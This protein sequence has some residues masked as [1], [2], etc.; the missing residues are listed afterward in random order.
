MAFAT[1]GNSPWLRRVRIL[2]PLV[3]ILYHAGE[4]WG[5]APPPGAPAA[6]PGAAAAAPAAPA[7]GPGGTFTRFTFL[8]LDQWSFVTHPYEQITGD[9]DFK[10]SR[11][12]AGGSFSLGGAPTDAN[13][14]SLTKLIHNLPPFGFEWGRSTDVF[15]PK[16]FTVGFDFYHFY[17]FDTNAARHGSVPPIATDT[18]LYN[19][20]VR[21]F[22]FDPTK[23][24]INY[25]LG[26]GL[27]ILEGTMRAKPY[28]GQSAEF[29]SYSQ[30]P[31]GTTRMGLDAKG[32]NF[33]FRYELL[34]V[35]ADRV[36]LA[37]NPYPGST[38]KT[39]DFS[40]AII[41]LGLF[42]EFK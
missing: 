18:F 26:V 15:L 6:A 32:E 8:T 25:F 7:G 5:Q 10:T 4:S 35:N 31:F 30:N 37:K 42:Y 41:R 3:L 2:L 13:A 28:S 39:I 9:G 21:V 34:L 17:Q 40:G 14:N 20:C 33:G 22:A 23:P 19:A 29:V 38:L 12:A 36:N 16:A 1:I 24:G 11:A 27:G